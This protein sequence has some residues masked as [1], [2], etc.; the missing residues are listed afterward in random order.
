MAAN[1]I[2]KYLLPRHPQS[3][4]PSVGIYRVGLG[5]KYL[6]HAEAARVAREETIEKKTMQRVVTL[7]NV[8]FYCDKW[9]L[10][11]NFLPGL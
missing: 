6:S 4:H 8:T 10:H 9:W 11:C 2:T 7:Q 1:E 3:T 5:A